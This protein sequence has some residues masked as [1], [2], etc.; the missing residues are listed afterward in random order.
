MAGGVIQPVQFSDWASPIVPVLKKDGSLRICVDFKLT[1][2][3]V[4]NS[5]VYPLP[6]VDDLL[7]TLSSEDIFTKLD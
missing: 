4:A 7:A 6:M 1:V 3:Q 5:D 2:I